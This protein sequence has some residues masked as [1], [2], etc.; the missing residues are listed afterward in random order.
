MA[1]LHAWQYA[2][3]P[4]SFQDRGVYIHRESLINV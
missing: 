4:A 3:S 1:S 2:G